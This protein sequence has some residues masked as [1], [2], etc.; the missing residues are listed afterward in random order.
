MWRKEHIWIFSVLQ[1]VVYTFS[2]LLTSVLVYKL[3]S[4]FGFWINFET[5]SYVVVLRV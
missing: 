1:R 4:L 3:S 5:M 2:I